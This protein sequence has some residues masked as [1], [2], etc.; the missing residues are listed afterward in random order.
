MVH[1]MSKKAEEFLDA[2]LNLPEVKQVYLSPDG[3]QIAIS[4][5]NLHAN[6]D[7]FLTPAED[8]EPV[9]PLTNTTER[10]RLLKWWP[11]S[12]SLIIAEDKGG[13]ERIALYRIFLESPNDWQQLT[14][15]NPN[16]YVRGAEIA[17][18]GNSLYYFVNY[19]FSKKNE[20]ETFKL[21]HQDIKT[22]EISILTSVDK[23]AYNYPSLNLAGTQILY[24]RS[25]LTPGGKQYWVIRTDGSDDHEILNF[26]A[27]AKVSASWHPDSEHIIFTTDSYQGDRLPTR[28]TGI[29]SVNTGKIN[30]IIAPDDSSSHDFNIAFVPR[31]APSTLVLRETQKAK[32]LSY[33]YNLDT[34]ELQAFP[35]LSGTLKPLQRLKNGNWLGIYY[36][37][38]QPTTLVSF[39]VDK[40]MEINYNVFTSYFDNFAHSSITQDQLVSAQE[41]DWLSEDGLSIHGWFYKSQNPTNRAIIYVHGG[42]TAH[43]EDRLNIEIQ[44][45]VS[46]G[47]HV[48]DPNY[49][50]STGYGVQFRET[51]KED[52]WGGREQV[53]IATGAQEIINQGFIDTKR[54]GITGTSY[55]GYSTWCAI[56]KFPD[57]F[58][59]SAP[60]CGMTNLIIDYE[61][62]RP[63]LRPLSAEMMGGIPEEVPERYKNGSPI[64]YINN[65][66]GS[67]FIIQGARDPNVTPENVKAVKQALEA[68]NI[69]YHELIFNDEGHGIIKKKNQRIK[70]LRISKFF[71]QEL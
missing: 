64:N 49:R 51:I 43:S 54:I 50:G 20:T 21:I 17:P 63:D 7:V 23:P 11:D 14:P 57:L 27:E 10:T 70:I 13:N 2:L 25:D 41:F 29:Y 38:K 53:D 37:S 34:N 19:D 33:F 62:T 12:Q 47:F 16:Y 30:W 56:T 24:N 65:I 40:L 22:E 4:I 67:I 5:S 42:P 3:N 71:D 32:S 44:Y 9:N 31:F 36:S 46:Q 48:L 45:Y 61:T 35:R 69:E 1:K 58:K 66:K 15:E 60:V 26:G 18:D 68:N 6:W 52:G 55:G 8:P 28:L 59:A 39:S